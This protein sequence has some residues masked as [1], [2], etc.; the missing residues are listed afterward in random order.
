MARFPKCRAIPISSHRFFYFGKGVSYTPKNSKFPQSIAETRN[1]PSFTK[2]RERRARPE[3]ADEAHN[4]PTA[5]CAGDRTPG[6]KRGIY[7]PIPGRLGEDQSNRLFPRWIIRIQSI[8]TVDYG[9]YM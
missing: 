4:L 3:V 2:N 9:D 1:P 7:T 6:L 5:Y 8:V